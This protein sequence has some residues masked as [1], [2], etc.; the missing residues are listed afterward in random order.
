MRPWHGHATWTAGGGT[1][2]GAR[3]ALQFAR[4]GGRAPVR[5]RR[6][7]CMECVVERICAQRCEVLANPCDIADEAATD[8]ALAS[9]ACRSGCLAPLAMGRWRR[10]MDVSARRAVVTA[11]PGRVPTP[12]RRVAVAGAGPGRPVKA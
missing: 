8:G 7:A 3:M 4:Q 10:Q 2:L 11:V 1:G 12:S 6:S 5:G 9:I